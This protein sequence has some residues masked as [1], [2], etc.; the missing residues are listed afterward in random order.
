MKQLCF[1]CSEGSIC[2]LG[3]LQVVAAGEPWTCALAPQ[4]RQPS[5]A[6]CTF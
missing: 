4:P 2:R 1:P 3:A 6:Q 5:F